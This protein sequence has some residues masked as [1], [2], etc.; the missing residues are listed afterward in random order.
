M[1][2][3]YMKLCVL[4]ELVVF[5]HSIF[6]LPF[7]FVSMMVA[8]NFQN[9]SVWFGFKV[10]ILGIICAVSARNFAMAVNRFLD[11]D[12]DKD[13]PRCKQRPNLN[14]RID[15][16]SVFVFIVSNALIFILATYFINDLA[17]YLSFLILFI[18][19]AYSTFK[20]F[21]SLAHIVLGFCLGLASVAGSVIVLGEIKLYSLI[22]CIGIM[23]WTAGFDLLYSIQD[24]EYDRIK[25]L[26]SIP[27]KFGIKT[28]LFLSAFFH[29]LA[30]VFWIWF[31]YEA[32]LS[33]ISFIGIALCAIILFLEQ[34]IVRK[35]FANIDKAFFTLNGYLSIVFFIFVW[36]DLL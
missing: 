15:R 17:F 35:N 29:F 34:L 11:E 4:L 13:N 22:L 33:Y 1:K 28:T 30:I 7:L 19:A 16:K 32:K 27:A 24:M 5:K 6:A 25:K 36:A 8:S 26:H 21:S 10:L 3:L 18:L 31:A 14:G 12:I 20:R 2:K 23:F 9:D